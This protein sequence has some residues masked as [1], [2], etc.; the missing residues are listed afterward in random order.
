M[1]LLLVKG[2]RKRETEDDLA[3][4][5]RKGETVTGLPA[6]EG[7]KS[8]VKNDSEFYPNCYRRDRGA[9]VVQIRRSFACCCCC[10]CL[11][12]W[13]CSHSQFLGWAGVED[14][15]GCSCR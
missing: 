5:A 10:C 11:R 14:E 7:Y 15:L 9:T 6:A 12:D 1:L 4:S 8:G 2:Q 3:I 13:L